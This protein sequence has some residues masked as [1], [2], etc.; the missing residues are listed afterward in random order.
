MPASDEAITCWAPPDMVRAVDLPREVLH[1]L[2][3]HAGTIAMLNGEVVTVLGAALGRAWP[4][5]HFCQQPCRY[6]H[7]GSVL[8][9]P[10]T[11]VVELFANG[12]CLNAFQYIEGTDGRSVAIVAVELPPPDRPERPNP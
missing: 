11:S 4:T 8:V 1:R 3:L 12:G 10:D 9:M 2:V 6:T 7:H 5:G